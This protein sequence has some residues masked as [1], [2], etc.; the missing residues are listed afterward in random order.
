ME[1]GCLGTGFRFYPESSKEL[2]EGFKHGHS[3]DELISGKDHPGSHA[4]S[5]GRGEARGRK[6]HLEAVSMVQ[7]RA[8]EILCSCGGSGP[9]QE[10]KMRGI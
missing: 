3:R 5:I 9:Q 6:T 4:N 1:P 10:T 7:V 2:L 8:K